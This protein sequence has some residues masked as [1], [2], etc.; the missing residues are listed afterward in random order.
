MAPEDTARVL[1]VAFQIVSSV[2]SA[3]VDG[4]V[5]YPTSRGLNQ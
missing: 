2:I 4:R 3:W 1:A 5:I